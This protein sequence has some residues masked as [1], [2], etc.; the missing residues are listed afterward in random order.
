M[1]AGDL[2]Q[3]EGRWNHFGH[4]LVQHGDVLAEDENG[5]LGVAVVTCDRGEEEGGEL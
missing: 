4:V 5:S 3:E 1:V 2:G